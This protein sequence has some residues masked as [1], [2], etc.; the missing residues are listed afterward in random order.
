MTTRALLLGVA[1][2]DCEVREEVV[3]WMV[4]VAGARSVCVD[5]GEE[6]VGVG[7]VVEA[8]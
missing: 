4:A 6:M 7:V 1:L 2:L 5:V 8:N 3:R